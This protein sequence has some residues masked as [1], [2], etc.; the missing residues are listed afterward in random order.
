MSTELQK[1][2]E[3]AVFAVVTSGDTSRLSK[4]QKAQYYKARCDAAGLDARTAPFQFITLQGREVLYALKGA[5]DQLAS[6][7]GIR[8]EICSQST[9]AGIRTVVVRAIAR[10]GRQTDEIGCVSVGGLG[11]DALCNAYMKAVTKAKRR[12]V[13][14]L[15]GL[16]MLDETEIET[17]PGA[18]QTHGAVQISE[19]RPGTA[20]DPI[21]DEDVPLEVTGVT[22]EKSEAQS[23][24]PAPPV[25]DPPRTISTKQQKRLF[26][27][28]MSAGWT[29]ESMR[30]VM[31]SE[32]GISHTKDI[33]VDGKLAVIDWKSSA[34]IYPEYAL[35]LAAYARAIK[36]EYGY[37]VDRWLVRL[38][39]TDGVVE[40]VK[41]PKST[42]SSDFRA[43]LCA[44]HLYRSKLGVKEKTA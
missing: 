11:G 33:G 32:F 8:L 21:T 16:G 9:D 2:A 34:A 28:A 24:P 14:S 26:A 13:L 27:I 25:S 1:C 12:A 30:S 35:Q 7:H 6:K 5:T 19:A 20:E 43:F 29:G 36:E 39:K 17:I 23:S 44:L 40:A 18:Q 4:E 22:Q 3:D 10:D 41:Y 15:C 31:H 37:R 38:G 42:Q